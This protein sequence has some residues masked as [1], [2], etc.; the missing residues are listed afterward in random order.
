MCEE[1]VSKQEQEVG[2]SLDEENSPHDSSDEDS[3]D[4]QDET[5]PGDKEL[6]IDEVD[7]DDEAE[8]HDQQIQEQLH[9]KFCFNVLSSVC[10]LSGFPALTPTERNWM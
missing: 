4:D 8:N 3:K 10:W 2:R 1:Y 5:V 7:I 9:E 6:D